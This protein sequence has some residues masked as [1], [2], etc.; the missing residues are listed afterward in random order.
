MTKLIV[1]LDPVAAGKGHHGGT[2]MTDRTPYAMWTDDCQ[3]KKDFDGPIISLSTRYWPG[4]E[5]GG[6]MMVSNVAG[7]VTIGTLP[8]GPRPSAHALIHLNIGPREDDDGG[9]GYLIWREKSFEADTEAAIKVEVEVWAKEQMKAII[10]LL[11][12]ESSF[13]EWSA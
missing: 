2:E 5:G 11:G 13:R 1:A 4:P 10:A 7:K 6:S 9:G 12:G 8:Y 3:G